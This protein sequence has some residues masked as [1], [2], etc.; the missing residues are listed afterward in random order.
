M[1]MGHR[2]WKDILRFV[3][4]FLA[5]LLLLVYIGPKAC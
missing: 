3:I 2:R 4:V 1:L 5:V